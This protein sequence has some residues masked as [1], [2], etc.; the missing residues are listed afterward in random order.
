MIIK[1]SAQ[2]KSI[3]LQ[4]LRKEWSEGEGELGPGGTSWRPTTFKG[5]GGSDKQEGNLVSKN[6]IFTSVSS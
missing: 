1:N 4:V 3:S 2:A 6:S 5:T